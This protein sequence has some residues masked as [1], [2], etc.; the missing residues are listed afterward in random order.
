MGND[1]VCTGVQVSV[2]VPA[3]N[4]VGHM[5]GIELLGH[6]V[7]SVSNSLRNHHAVFCHSCSI[8]HSSSSEIKAV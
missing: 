7:N 1:A 3:L 6:V 2:P 4:S 5:P 8:L